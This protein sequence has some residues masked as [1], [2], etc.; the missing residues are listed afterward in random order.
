MSKPRDAVKER[1]W[2]NLIRRHESSG[3]GTRRFCEEAG[4]PNTAF[5]GG[6]EFCGGGIS[7][8]LGKLIRMTRLELSVLARTMIA[9]RFFPSGYYFRSGLLG[10]PPTGRTRRCSGAVEQSP[11]QAILSLRA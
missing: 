8:M 6:V 10:L 3:L 7:T 9:Q 1:F 2:R 5:I 4:V 11:S